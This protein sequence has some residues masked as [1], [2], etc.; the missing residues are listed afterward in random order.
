MMFR[1]SSSNEEGGEREYSVETTRLSGRSG[2]IDTLH[3]VEIAIEVGAEGEKRAVRVGSERA[4][5][6]DLLVVA[7]GFDGAQ[8]G[9]I[10]AELGVRVDGR[11]NLR[12][13]RDHATSVDGVF[14]AGDA[15]RGASLI[16]WA[17]MDGRESARAIDRFLRGAAQPH[18]PTRGMDAD[19]GGPTHRV[20]QQL[21]LSVVSANKPAG[22]EVR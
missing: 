14:A 21:R 16:V 20:D 11:G 18:L 8:S 5:A 13:D 19:F 4:R 10:T 6:C 12:V 17:I 9:S 1:S 3:W 7:I 2:R 15:M 22:S